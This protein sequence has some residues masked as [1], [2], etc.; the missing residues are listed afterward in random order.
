MRETAGKLNRGWLTIIGILALLLGVVG[1]LLASGAAAGIA[2]AT[3]TG[4]E[5]A[6]P[7]ETA[8]PE[9]AQSIFAPP[10]AAVILSV[11]AVVVGLLALAWLL[12]QLPKL[13]QA[14]TF[15][16]NSGDNAD[17]MTSCEPD[18]LSDAVEADV[19]Q[20]DGVQAASALLR[21]SASQPD[22]TLDVGIDPR[23]DV[24]AVIEQI[25]SSV[26]PDFETAVGVPLSRNAVLINVSN[27]PAR[28][29]AA[30]V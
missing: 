9:N 13:H 29:K 6:G 11:V 25:H 15:R 12:A 23:A 18:V 30:V 26:V 5:P 16:L 3:G 14:G 28:D 20:L 22:L 17:G 27:R 10:V 7:G 4:F 8:L 21:G 24:R 19:E 1:I 2:S